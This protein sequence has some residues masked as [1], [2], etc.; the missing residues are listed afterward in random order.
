LLPRC[1]LPL[2]CGQRDVTDVLDI[3][4]ARVELV[5][6]HDAP[7][8]IDFD[9]DIFEIKAFDVWPAADGDEHNI[10]LKLM[11]YKLYLRQKKRGLKIYAP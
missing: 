9:T 6:D 1:P 3:W 4:H 7:A 2:P 8:R 11:V 5:V 10:C